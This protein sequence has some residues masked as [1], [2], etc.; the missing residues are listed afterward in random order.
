MHINKLRLIN[1]KNHQKWEAKFELGWVC[2]TGN[3]GV[4]KTN[5]LDAIWFAANSRSYFNPSDKELIKHQEPGF[6]IRAEFQQDVIVEVVC[7]LEEGKRKQLLVN[8]QPVKKLSE[9]IGRIPMVMITPFDVGLISE[10][11]EGRRRFMD[12]ALCKV[13]P[14]YLQAL[15]NYKKALENR[16]KQLKAFVSRG[17]RDLI[18]LQ[19]FDRILIK[20]A[21]IIFGF[22]KMFCKEI[23]NFFNILYQEISGKK[24]MATLEYQSQLMD[25]EMATWLELQLDKDLILERTTK[26]THQDDLIFSIDNHP[27]K[28]YGSQ[29]QS[30]SY[31]IALQL[32]LFQWLKEKKGYSPI[33]LL[34]DI[35]EKIDANR[36]EALMQVIDK[37]AP[38]QIFVTDTH[39]ERVNENLENVKLNKQFILL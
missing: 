10:G 36:S 25:R 28:K 19:S 38:K 33:L 13:Y 20:E 17:F 18:L 21:P 32:A 4:G 39:T 14:E 31:V 5:I 3:N 1:F 37:L 27:I 6:S 26:G 23:V 11:G 29:G 22:R 9:Y 34:D 12:I 7:R 16:N 30:K 2:I 24:E 15:D 35:F 8:E